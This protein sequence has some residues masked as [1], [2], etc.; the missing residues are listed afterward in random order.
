MV[1][2]QLYRYFLSQSSEFCRYKPLCC[3]S[4]I[5]Y[6]C[7][8]LFRYRLSPET[9]VYTV[10]IGHSV[11]EFEQSYLALLPC[12]FQPSRKVHLALSLPSLV[13]RSVQCF[14]VVLLQLPSNEAPRHENVLGEWWHISTNSMTS[15]LN[16]GEWSDSRPGLFTPTEKAHGTHWIGGWVGRR[17]GLE[18]VMKKKI[19]SPRRESNPRT[20]IIQPV[21]QRYTD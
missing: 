21:A 11:D 20:P 10:V 7:C 9:F 19:P 15:S 4:A 2:V 14:K 12:C 3:F 13:L 5:V 16:E 18:A 6:F 8:R 17:A 1:Q